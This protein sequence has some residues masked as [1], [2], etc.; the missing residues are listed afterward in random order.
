MALD[1]IKFIKLTGE[2]LDST[3]YA[4]AASDGEIKKPETNA[5]MKLLKNKRKKRRQLHQQ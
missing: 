1:D 5:S 3:A 2:V 4:K